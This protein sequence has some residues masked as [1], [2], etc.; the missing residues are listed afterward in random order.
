[1]KRASKSEGRWSWMN[2]LSGFLAA[3]ILGLGICNVLSGRPP[4]DIDLVPL[5]PVIVLGM[6]AGAILGGASQMEL[7]SGRTH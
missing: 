3:G 2:A 4:R 7:S 6:L 5:L 1:M